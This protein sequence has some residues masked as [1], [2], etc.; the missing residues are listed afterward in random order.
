MFPL[1]PYS[2]RENS[3]ECSNTDSIPT[4]PLFLTVNRSATSIQVIQPQDGGYTFSDFEYVLRNIRFA[5]GPIRPPSEISEYEAVV[6]VAAND[7]EHTSEIAVS[8]IIVTI[9][10]SPSVILFGND[11]TTEIVMRDGQPVVRV[12][13]VDANIIEDSD[14]ISHIT[15]TLT[16]PSHENERLY[17]LGGSA[18][19]SISITNGSNSV[20]LTGPASP[21]EFAEA[22]NNTDIFYSYP[23]MESILQGDVPDFTP[24]L[25]FSPGLA[26]FI[27]FR[28]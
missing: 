6:R 4:S 9:T 23:P 5:H 28:F 3:C 22:L 13:Q 26:Y 7:G 20:T 12:L 25:V 17:A 14:I 27:Q 11:S 15:L 1:C 8:R 10:N 24:R 18:S 2:L 21:L 16:N 19:S